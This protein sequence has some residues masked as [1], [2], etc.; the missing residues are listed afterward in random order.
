MLEYVFMAV[1]V[2][3]FI[4][5]M[6]MTHPVKLL[7]LAMLIYV[8]Y[9]QPLMGIVCAAIFIRQMPVEG[10][11]VHKKTP[12]RMA[13]DEQVRP[14][15]SNSIRATKTGGVPPEVSLSGLTAKPYVENHSGN[16]TPF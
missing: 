13:L 16:Y 8:S 5:P 12:T 10:M 11:V 6:R 15:D 3:L 9:K 7:E 2:L 4:K 1:F 14:K